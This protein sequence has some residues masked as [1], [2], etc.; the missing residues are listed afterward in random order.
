[1][2]GIEGTCDSGSSNCNN[3]RNN[4]MKRIRSIVVTKN[5]DVKE[6]EVGLVLKLSFEHN[7]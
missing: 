2:K 3:N 6:E 5:V 7:V 4:K 1:M